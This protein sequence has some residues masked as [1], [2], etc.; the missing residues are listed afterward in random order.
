MF[1]D[2][3]PLINSSAAAL[4]HLRQDLGELYALLL[5]RHPDCPCH[6]ALRIDVQGQ[7]VDGTYDYRWTVYADSETDLRP[8]RFVVT[9]EVNL[10]FATVEDGDETQEI[11]LVL[12]I[13]IKQDTGCAI[14]GVE[15]SSLFDTTDDWGI[16]VYGNGRLIERNVRQP[17]GLTEVLTGQQQSAKLV[18]GRLL[19]RG[20]SYA[21]PWDTHKT[22]IASNHPTLAA[23]NEDLAQIV[24]AYARA[25]KTAGRGKKAISTKLFPNPWSRKWKATDAK[26]KPLSLAF[27][28]NETPIGS[29]TNAGID[30]PSAR[31]ESIKNT[32][33]LKTIAFKVTTQQQNDLCRWLRVN[34][35]QLAEA[36]KKKIL[37][38]AAAGGRA[39]SEMD[40]IDTQ[41]FTRLRESIH[42]PRVLAKLQAAGLR[43]VNAIRAAGKKGL[44]AAGLEA[45]QIQ[46]VLDAIE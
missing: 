40:P 20:S 14:E 36:I 33:G 28:L 39:S 11:S 4:Q 44:A 29:E 9:K 46:S 37:K 41:A 24:Q 6:F 25:A 8:R 32:K 16:D 13:G 17:L 2:L 7:A 38:V 18:K 22:R 5:R 26:G 10:P 27:D 23:V 12:E 30:L 3:K 43:S 34:E 42:D 35:K 45:K 19:I 15:S 31:R 1:K 21:V